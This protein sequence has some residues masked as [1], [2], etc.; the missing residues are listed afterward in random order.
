MKILNT[1][2]TAFL[3]AALAG[4]AAGQGT[5][6]SES[7][8]LH[9]GGLGGGSAA[10][11]SFHADG[12][13]PIGTAL[14]RSA[15]PNFVLTGGA[16]L[17][18]GVLHDGFPVVL[19]FEPAAMQVEGGLL[20]VRGRHL[21]DLGPGTPFL[22]TGA[23]A[24]IPPVQFGPET[25]HYVVPHVADPK[26]NPY[27]KLELALDTGEDPLAMTAPLRFHLSLEADDQVELG[28]TIEARAYGVPGD[29]LFIVAGLDDPGAHLALPDW[30]GSLAVPLPGML[31]L[32]SAASIP[33]G[34]WYESNWPAAS[35]PAAAGQ[36]VALQAAV[37]DM[38]LLTLRFSNVEVIEYVEP[39]L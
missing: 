22:V 38:D 3:A 25:A 19:G 10:S 35:G 29:P 30:I 13:V 34:G 28:G 23:L 2:S 36:R 39:D 15:S 4:A 20:T 16:D 24:T 12:G 31:F 1:T 26:G 37:L 11:P 8:G 18:D 17:D 5:S 27:S 33:A 32:E 9:L 21:D 14:G 7:Y 6:A